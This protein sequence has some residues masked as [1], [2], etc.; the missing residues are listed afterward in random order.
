VFGQGGDGIWRVSP[1]GGQPEV[2]VKVKDG[3]LAHGPQVL[4][5]GEVVLFTLATGEGQWD[6][7]QIVVQSIRTGERWIVRTGGTDARYLPT[8][9][10]VYAVG[11]TLFA[12]RFDL[13][14]LTVVGDQTPVIQGIKRG[15]GEPGTAQFSVSAT[16]SL[17]YQAGPLLAAGFQRVLAEVDA[18]GHVAFLKLPAGPY[19]APRYAPV[20]SLVAVE[21]DEG[22]LSTIGTYDLS[23]RTALQRLTL[24]GV[25]RF[26]IWSADGQR[27]AFQSDREGDLGIFWQRADGTGTVERLT[28]PDPGMAHR[29]DAWARDGQTLLF[30]EVKDGRFSLWTL[31]LRDQKIERFG[32]VETALAISATFSRSGRWVAYTGP[33]GG[34]VYVEPFPRTGARYAAPNGGAFA[35]FWASDDR[36]LFYGSLNNMFY[37]VTFSTQ[38]RVEFG[39][40][41]AVARGGL[42]LLSFASPRNWDLSP[43]GTRILGTVDAHGTEERSDGASSIQVVTNWFQELQRLLPTN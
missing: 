10:L 26:P 14:R 29:P 32:T 22:K 13:A 31:S 3:E 25:N 19:Q 7:A 1:N 12:A 38:P 43:D 5:N 24:G 17:I 42:M 18:S 36:A 41:E 30:E 15:T 9:H 11:G 34:R 35:P 21:L 20:G 28:K 16:G 23:G 33:P 6:T 8:G 27:V 4:R 39:N 2:L 37:R 40:P